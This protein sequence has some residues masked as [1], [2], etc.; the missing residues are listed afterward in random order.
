MIRLSPPRLR[1]SHTYLLPAAIVSGRATR[2]ASGHDDDAAQAEAEK[3]D[4]G[5][6][7]GGEGDQMDF[8]APG[9]GQ[10]DEGVR[11][12]QDG[13]SMVAVEPNAAETLGRAEYGDREG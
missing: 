9:A 13:R 1:W 10:P 7:E 3:Q 8:D 5:S 6:D 2:L 12:E 11:E 4:A